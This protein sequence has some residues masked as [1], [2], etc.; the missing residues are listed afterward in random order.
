MQGPNVR[1]LIAHKMARDAVPS[2][3][4]LADALAFLTRKEAIVASARAATEW[5]ALAIRAVREAGEPNPWR[6][7]SDEEIAG[8]LLRRIGGK[9]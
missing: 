9:R 6:E 7:A 2:G 5:V 1:K 8:E 4:G 3:G